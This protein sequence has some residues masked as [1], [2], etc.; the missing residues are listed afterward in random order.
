MFQIFISC[1]GRSSSWAWVS[2]NNLTTRP[3][4]ALRPLTSLVSVA[5]ASKNQPC[6]LFASVFAV[7]GEDEEVGVANTLDDVEFLQLD[8]FARTA[9]DLPCFYTVPCFHLTP[10]DVHL[11][12]NL[13]QDHLCNM[14]NH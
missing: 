11:G 13:S 9:R 8:R 2:S 14:R 7:Q 3:V 1:S 5:P 6:V 4:V 12:T 10:L